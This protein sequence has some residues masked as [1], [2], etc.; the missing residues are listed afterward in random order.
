MTTGYINHSLQILPTHMLSRRAL[1]K[2]LLKAVANCCRPPQAGN[3]PVGMHVPD[4][5]WRRHSALLM[6][7]HEKYHGRDHG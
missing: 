2:R 6:T 3:K 7:L 4:R 1:T 5:T